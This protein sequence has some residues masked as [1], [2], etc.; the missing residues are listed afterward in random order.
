MDI[1]DLPVCI[2]LICLTFLAAVERPM[3]L[4]RERI[5]VARKPLFCFCLGCLM[6]QS[7]AEAIILHSWS[8]SKYQPHAYSNQKQRGYAHV[9]A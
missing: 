4:A 9:A 3:L 5:A 7:L 2:N 6:A 8:S 1:A